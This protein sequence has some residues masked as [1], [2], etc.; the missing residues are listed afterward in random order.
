MDTLNRIEVAFIPSVQRVLCSVQVSYLG[1]LAFNLCSHQ[2][3]RRDSVAQVML[4][5]AKFRC[6]IRELIAGLLYVLDS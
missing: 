6:V 2:D 5:S 4:S 1:L 3:F